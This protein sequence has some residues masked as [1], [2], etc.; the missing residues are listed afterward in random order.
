MPE[1]KFLVSP[2]PHLWRGQSVSKIMYIVV[3]ALIFP[4]AAGVYFFG[5]YALSVVAVSVAAAVLTEYGVKKLRKRAFVI[6]GSAVVTGLL[7][8]LILPP[9]IPLWMAAVGSVFSIAIVKEA[10][11]GLGHNIF[12]PA[13]G[14]RAFL[15][16][17]FSV[18]MTTWV[19]PTGFGADAV[20]TATPLSSFVWEGDKL[21]LYRDLFLGNTGGSIGETS[22]LLILAGGILLLALGIISWRIPV[23][24]I[25][26]VALLTLA[27]GQ[28][29]IFHIL[30]GG[31]MLGAFFMATDYVTSPITARG[32]IIFGI[33]AGI[34][35]VVIR[36]FGGLPEGV[37]YSILFMNAL[38]PLI[39]RYVR[40]RPYGLVKKVKG[41][42]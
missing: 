35:T 10:F 30:A 28:D 31:L 37:C 1:R 6:D 17:C 26:T 14:G 25:G 11:G 33:G 42:G 20:T 41:E 40:V 27:L 22:A 38:T 23:A 29:A 34:L 24:Y 19:S 15:A 5:Y 32:K 18:K 9:T 12:N 16:A 4:T 8:A 3:L 21:S 2:G 7:L 36:R 13:L 39:D